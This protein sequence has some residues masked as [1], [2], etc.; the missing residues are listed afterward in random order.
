MPNPKGRTFEYATWAFPLAPSVA[1][2]AAAG[3]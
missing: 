2:L 3:L 1:R